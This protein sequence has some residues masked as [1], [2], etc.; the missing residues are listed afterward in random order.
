MLG[1]LVNELIHDFYKRSYNASKVKLLKKNWQFSF[2]C[3]PKISLKKLR[4][5]KHESKSLF[6]LILLKNKY[7]CNRTPYCL[8]TLRPACIIETTNMVVSTPT[9]AKSR[10]DS[11]KL[12][13]FLESRSH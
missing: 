2:I 9:E 5:S 10:S 1:Y 8:L 4:N 7:I 6:S 13:D 11:E 12:P 3:N